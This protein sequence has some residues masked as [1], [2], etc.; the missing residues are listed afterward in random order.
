[1]LPSGARAE[2]LV[3]LLRQ[4]SGDV[5]LLS[6]GP[7]ELAVDQLARVRALGIP[8]IETPIAAL[9]GDDDGRLR[10]V[11]FDNGET[12]DRDALFFFVGWQLRNDVAR[13]LGC[14][15]HDDGSIAVDS[16]QA[17]TDDRVYAEAQAHVDC[18]RRGDAGAGGRR[19][20]RPRVGAIA[21]EDADHAVVASRAPAPASEL[22]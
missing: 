9:D 17:T 3:L 8:L 14:R 19:H 7:H 11:R 22:S 13:T 15:L 6:N 20:E 5:V 10:S 16:G 18:D 4:W 21:G 2:H 12:L 1:V